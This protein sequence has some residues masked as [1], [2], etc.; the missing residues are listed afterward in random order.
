MHSRSFSQSAVRFQPWTGLAL[1]FAGYFAMLDFAW[2][3]IS[4]SSGM[5]L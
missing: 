5:V 3:V 2:M 4:V 1:V